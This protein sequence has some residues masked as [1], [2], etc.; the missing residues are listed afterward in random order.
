MTLPSKVYGFLDIT[1]NWDPSL[2]LVMIGAIGVHA[3]ALFLLRHRSRAFFDTEFRPPLPTAIDAR[4]LIGAAVFGVGWGLSGYC[5]GPAIVSMA[6][7][8]SS[9]I[10]FTFGMLVGIVAFRR[11]LPAKAD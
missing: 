2:M 10:V 9:A 7:G 1:G 6:S 5:P 8:G 11:L 3:L 4:L